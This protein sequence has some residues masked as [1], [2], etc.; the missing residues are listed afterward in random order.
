MKDLKNLKGAK[1]LSKNDQRSI[2]GGIMICDIYNH[3]CPE[4]YYCDW[5]NVSSGWCLPNNPEA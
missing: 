3:P 1:M 4:G 5:R 2:K